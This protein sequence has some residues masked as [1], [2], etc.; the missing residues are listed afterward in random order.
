MSDPLPQFLRA[1][2]FVLL[3]HRGQ[4]LF[5]P[6]SPP[7]AWLIELWQ[8][9]P[10]GPAAIAIA[11]KSPFLETFLFEADAF[12][13]SNQHGLCQSETWVETSSSGKE[14]PLQAIALQLEGQRFLAL[15]S[16]QPEFEE[17]VR[18]LQTARN[19]L[20]DHEKLQR[21]IQ[22]KEI[23]L[24]CIIHDLSQPLS[25]M[26][27]A[28]DCISA[29]RLNERAKG[30]LELGRK[31]SDQQ[32]TMISDILR[33]F[34]ADLQ[35]STQ[36]GNTDNSTADLVACANSVL[37]AFT[38]VYAAKSVQ[39]RSSG[40]T[41]PTLQV[42]GEPSRIE[43]IFSNLLEN[44]LRYS[45]PGTTATLGLETGGEFATAYIDD[46]GPGLPPDL[47][48]K[49]IFA[50]FSKGKQGGGKAGLGLYFCRLTV[51]RWGGAIGCESL[52][53][54]GSRFWFRLPRA[55]GIHGTR[56]RGPSN[57]P[58]QPRN[59]IARKEASDAHSFGR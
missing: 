29:E 42:R 39:L 21:E 7:P 38:P 50:L 51:E 24:H 56:E 1:L 26:S 5:T 25:V 28:F 40:F 11:E 33:V 6:L 8:L 43:R 35:S 54:A 4:G 30:L 19:S 48:Q 59:S 53:Q 18:L 17:R 34:S 14:F 23:L 52:P 20:L 3:Q 58:R 36:P 16:P 37:N 22:K 41:A 45:P 55:L 47:P 12:W 32:L 13:N 46:Q 10:D 2:G 49:Q 31:A 9:P 57:L 27:V 44:A 15:R